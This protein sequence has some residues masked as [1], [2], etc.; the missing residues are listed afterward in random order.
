MVNCA[1]RE[2]GKRLRREC[3]YYKLFFFC[4][5][6]A[7]EIKDTAHTREV[8]RLLHCAHTIT[9][10]CERCELSSAFNGSDFRYIYV[11]DRFK[12]RTDFKPGP[13]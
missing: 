13:I 6:E 3:E 12:T 2:C 10:N 8:N 1:L 5:T 4:I 7:I 9:H 11:K